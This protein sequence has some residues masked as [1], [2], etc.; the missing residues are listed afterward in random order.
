MKDF[1]R[2]NKS[3]AALAATLVLFTVLLCIPA[4]IRIFA[5]VF[6]YVAYLYLALGY[7]Y[8]ILRVKKIK[9]PASGRR[10]ALFAAA[11]ACA[12]MT[13]HVGLCGRELVDSGFGG[14]VGGSYETPT[15]A[16]VVF[17]LISLPVVLPCKY[18][19]SVVIFFLLTA[20]CGFFVIKPWVF[21]SEKPLKK[22]YSSPEEKGE[23]IYNEVLPE[24]KPFVS[25]DEKEKREEITLL[26]EEPPVGSREYARKV[27]FGDTP[28]IKRE[29]PRRVTAEEA[30]TLLN[31][32]SSFP[33]KNG[34]TDKGEKKNSPYSIVEGVDAI[35]VPPDDAPY[36]NNYME[37]KREEA[38][39]KLFTNTL[40]DDYRLRYGGEEDKTLGEEIGET[41]SVNPYIPSKTIFESE[42]GAP[43][44]LGGETFVSDETAPASDEEETDAALLIS[45]GKEELPKAEESA[46]LQALRSDGADAPPPA[47]TAAIRA[48]AERETEKSP[49]REEARIHIK[50]QPSV[51]I[52]AVKPL[53]APPK[54]IRPYSAPKINMLVDHV[55]EGFSPYVDNYRDL[56]E[57]FEVKL[58]NFNIDVRLVDVVKGPTITLCIL[59]LSEKCPISKVFSIKQDISRLLKTANNADINIVPKIPGS[60]YF[61]IEVP[62]AVKG[63]VSF[64]EVIASSDYANAK[65]DI[66]LALGKTNSGKIVV[67][68]LADM[69][70]A[71]IAGSTGSGKSVCINAILASILYRYSPDEVK[72]ILID[73]KIVEMANFGGLPHMLF[74]EPLNEIPEVI[75]ALKWLREETFRR[76]NL[77]KDMR[78]RNLNEYNAKLEKEQKIPR[79]VIIIDEASELMSDPTGRKTVE[80]TLSSL[81]RVARAAGVHMIFA[82]QNPVKEVITNEIQNNL[83]T[84]IAFAV[85]DYVHSMVIF[86][87]PGAEKLLGKG[88]MIIKKGSDMQRAQC[89]FISTDE[90]ESMV[91]YI[92]DNNDVDFDEDMIERILHGSKEEV[93]LTQAEVR[94]GAAVPEKKN[95]EE[96]EGFLALAKESLRIFVETDRVSATYI[97]RRFSKGYNTVANVMDYLEDKGYISPQVNN[98]RKLL[99]TKDD[100]YTLYPDE[101]PIG[102]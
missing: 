2:K 29:P 16:G 65:G 70:H 11:F 98:K 83:N 17:S 75:N 12:L 77:F 44:K 88:D 26:E 37:K 22:K 90:I 23:R 33:R 18:I 10:L 66:V 8:L 7:G 45:D 100:F 95:L 56:Q 73:L 52:A 50:E 38:R 1:L 54:E 30:G 62:N 89:A 60:S 82:T 84:K 39:N 42:N 81:A 69:P 102:E 51:T 24:E 80:Q 47:D 74:K 87:A 53:P 19:A 20:V 57:V 3:S 31:G 46:F 14:Y 97:Q 58:K 41:M 21:E 4:T 67:D 55:K 48:G 43:P 92:K 15:A 94:S 34:L 68:D 71:L 9:L 59:E 63:I 86:K 27:L 25:P 49:A 40:S 79:I 61:G 32:N 101:K 93:P 6:G 91:A 35:L 28:P 5:G 76:F 96:D 85:G 72:L 13:L 78:V 36:T 64:K 99:I